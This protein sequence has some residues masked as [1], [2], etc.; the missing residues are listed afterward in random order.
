MVC[1]IFSLRLSVDL[2]TRCAGKAEELCLLEM[3]NNVL[4][5]IT[6]LTAVALV[7]NEDNLSRPYRHP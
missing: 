5:H 3:P 7:N 6:K 4:V 1:V 2:K